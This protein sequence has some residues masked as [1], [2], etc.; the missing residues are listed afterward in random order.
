MDQIPDPQS[1]YQEYTPPP[2]QT[3]RSSIPSSIRSSNE[4]PQAPYQAF[5]LYQ[6]QNH[7]LPLPPGT[8]YYRPLS[9]VFPPTDDHEVL[10]PP[11]THIFQEPYLASRPH[12]FTAPAHYSFG[13]PPP[14]LAGPS[15]PH[16]FDLAAHYPLG[17]P[18]A[19]LPG[20]SR[21]YSFDPSRHQSF[22]PTKH[23]SFGQ[24][25]F[26]SRSSTPINDQRR[27]TG[28]TAITGLPSVPHLA[29]DMAWPAT[30]VTM[31]PISAKGSII[32]IPGKDHMHGSGD[33]IKENLENLSEKTA[34]S[35]PSTPP[36]GAAPP[37]APGPP[38]W[39]ALHNAG[40]I[41]CVCLAQFLSLCALAQT[42]APLIII[43]DNLHVT[44]PGQ[45]SWFTAAYSMTLG[46]FI[47]PS[48]RLS[49]ILR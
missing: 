16:S 46:T 14:H 7:D 8:L 38:T 35:G 21:H 43:G 4:V 20:P 31:T 26:I 15:R 28:L 3:E 25:S 9:P 30:P 41:L 18:Q 42:V 45:L 17:V 39:S 34:I 5:H 10:R 24:Q 11:A 37:G 32:D 2:I 27:L 6:V 33:S 1:S 49:P 44:N 36:P 19:P 40:F 13:L 23:N 12:S 47:I 22:D 29:Q 48:G